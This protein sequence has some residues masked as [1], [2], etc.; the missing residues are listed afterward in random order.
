VHQRVVQQGRD[1]LGK[2]AGGDVGLQPGI[3]DQHHLPAGPPEGGL[4]LRDLL[5]HDLVDADPARRPGPDPSG[6][7]EQLA[8]HVGEP[9]GLGERGG[10]LLADHGR[11]IGRRDH[12]LEPHGQR[13]QR[14]AELVRGVDREL[15]IGRQQLGN[16]AGGAVEA[17]RDLVELGDAV[18]AADRPGVAG[19]EAAGRLGQFLDRPGRPPGHRRRE[20]RRHA[21][22]G[23]QQ[24]Q[25]KREHD[26]IAVGGD[27]QQRN[28]GD[29]R[30][31]HGDGRRRQPKPTPHQYLP[32]GMTPR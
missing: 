19:A 23:G 26:V 1:D 29:K 32:R 8:H 30:G 6:R 4:P 27:D 31:D 22:R 20:R 12:L 5:Q 25:A 14:R 15:A 2:A 28:R 21:D 18:P 10:A 24:R 11:V 16:P 7:G 17:L 13:R 9:L 3:P